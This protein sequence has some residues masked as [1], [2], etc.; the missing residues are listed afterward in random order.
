MK[1]TKNQSNPPDG[2]P[3]A[4]ALAE[5]VRNESS[6]VSNKSADSLD[7]E[8]MDAEALKKED[9]IA[10]STARSPSY[11]LT[12]NRL[13]LMALSVSTIDPA[14]YALGFYYKARLK[15]EC[16]LL[17]TQPVYRHNV[18]AIWNAL[19]FR[20]SNPNYFICSAADM[21][22]TLYLNDMEN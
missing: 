14:R 7:E 19:Y 21:I 20:R 5:H 1:K 13:F 22:L 17:V 16:S 11:P 3:F 2:T 10:E 4:G 6:A 12:A 9:K 18:A 8:H 15:H